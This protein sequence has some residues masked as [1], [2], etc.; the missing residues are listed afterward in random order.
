MRFQFLGS[1]LTLATLSAGTAQAGGF[2]T[3]PQSA[4]LLGLSGASTAYIN[5]IAGISTNPGLL[6]HYADS[7]TRIVLGG[8]GL[9]RRVSFVGLNS[10]L[11]ASQ[12]LAVVPGGYAYAT[13]GVNKRV[14]VGLAITTPYAFHTRW[15]DNWEGRSVVQ[16]SQLNTYFVQPT[17]AYRL[18]DNFNIGAGFIYAFGKYSQRRA[19][20]QYDDRTAQASFSGTG[21]GI[22]ATV[23]LYG[24]TGDNLSFGISYNT[25]VKL[26]INSG[27][28]TYANVPGRDASLY[29]ASASFR[30]S[31]N[32]PTGL[33]IG[34]ADRVTKNLLVTFDFA[35]SGWSTLDS[36]NFDVQASGAA[37]RQRVPS[38]RSYEDALAFRFGAEYVVTPKLTLLGGFHY[39]ETPVR[40]EYITPDY[41]DASRL[42]ASLGLSYQLSPKL[43]LEAAYAFDYGQNRTSRVDITKYQVANVS[44]DYRTVNHTAAL[45]VAMS[46]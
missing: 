36:L 13:Y 35:L 43:A 1:L 38:R 25:G 23:G 15:D 22:G 44:G 46:F 17:V 10:D 21:S 11:G 6:G 16:E 4:R 32:L 26:K 19:L 31:I 3:G 9:V 20:G 29:P 8:T 14:A 24:R 41:V 33:T 37:P 18:S 42:G 45:G 12:D 34:I 2:D 30:S 5:S 27:S 28:A 39:D 40:D 7:L